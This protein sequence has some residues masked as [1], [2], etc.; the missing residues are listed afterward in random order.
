MS[1][2][3]HQRFAP[4][5]VAVIRAPGQL[6]SL[7]NMTD[8]YALRI[9]SERAPTSEHL[10]QAA[11]LRHRDRPRVLRAATGKQAKAAAYLSREQWHPDWY[12]I[13]V[14]VMRWCLAVKLS[15]H[16][17]EIAP[18]LAGTKSLPIVEWSRKDSFWGAIPQ[19]D[20]Q[21]AGRNCL[22]MV[23]AEL[24][25]IA[26]AGGCPAVAKRAVQPSC[27]RGDWLWTG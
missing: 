10:Y 6:P 8:G 18:I 15:Q 24:R 3:E 2:A 4:G 20:G 22:G 19:A 13:R 23:W 12:E 1:A 16:W 17:D 7:A 11:K 27:L 26:W 25:D 14:D 5:D 9:G 21:L